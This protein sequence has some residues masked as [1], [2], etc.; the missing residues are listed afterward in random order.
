VLPYA[1]FQ[2]LGFDITQRHYGVDVPARYDLR[3]TFNL[4]PLRR[5]NETRGSKQ[6]H[7]GN[8]L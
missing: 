6:S 1:I 8:N 7:Y 2:L 3:E 5:G 4:A